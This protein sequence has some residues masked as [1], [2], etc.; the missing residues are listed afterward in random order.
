MDSEETYHPFSE[1]LVPPRYVG[2]NIPSNGIPASE[3]AM[4]VKFTI[5]HLQHAIS[6]KPSRLTPQRLQQGYSTW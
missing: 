4:G 5:S 3:L 1:M 2:C 6:L